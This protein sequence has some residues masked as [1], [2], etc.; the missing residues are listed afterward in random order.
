VTSLSTASCPTIFKQKTSY[1]WKRRHG[2]ELWQRGYID[3]ILR[4]D[5]DTLTVARYILDNPVRAGLV[6]SPLDYPFSGSGTMDLRDVLE[7]VR[8]T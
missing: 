1:E 6:A 2:V 8:R 7:S 5:E 3:R 4:A